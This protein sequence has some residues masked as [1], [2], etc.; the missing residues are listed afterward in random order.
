MR[1]LPAQRRRRAC[2]LPRPGKTAELDAWPSFATLRPTPAADVLLP[3]RGW[4]ARNGII[5]VDGARIGGHDVSYVLSHL[6]SDLTNRVVRTPCNFLRND[7][8]TTR[9]VRTTH[10]RACTVASGDV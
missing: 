2:R 5:S 4:G 8:N 6:T 3:H 9:V 1:C 10:S 7:E